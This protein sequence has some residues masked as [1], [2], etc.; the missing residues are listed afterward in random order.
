MNNL[1]SRSIASDIKIIKE[2]Y[3]VSNPVVAEIIKAKVERFKILQQ[4][5]TQDE[6]ISYLLII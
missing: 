5:N 6:V 3:D 1:I 2:N 4:L